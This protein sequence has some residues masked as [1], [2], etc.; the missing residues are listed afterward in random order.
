MLKLPFDPVKRA[1]EVENLVMRDQKRKYYRFRGARYYGG[2]AT[3]D[4]V[5]CCFLC[6]YC[7]N[8]ERNMK[9]EE[10]KGEFCSSEQ[11]ARRLL[12]ICNRRDFNKVRLSGAEPILGEKS[13]EHIIKIIERVLSEKPTLDFILETNGFILALCIGQYQKALCFHF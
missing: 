12:D 2:I 7:W 13:F 9:P 5:G 11:V 6:A 3:A 8:Y 1:E 10:C 4:M